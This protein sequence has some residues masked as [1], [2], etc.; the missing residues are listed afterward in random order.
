M[1]DDWDD[2][3]DWDEE[4]EGYEEESDEEATGLCPECRAE[5]HVDAEMC[6]SCGY[7]LTTADRHRMW[8]DESQVKGLMSVGKI[9]LVVILIALMS[10]LAVIF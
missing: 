6:P 9:V 10:G 5:I 7:W 3:E 2:E 8:D 4:D 1:S